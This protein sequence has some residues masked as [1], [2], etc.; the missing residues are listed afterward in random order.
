MREGPIYE[1]L[2]I[3][4]KNYQC[5]IMN[6]CYK[7]FNSDYIRHIRNALSHGTFSINIAG[8]YFKDE[9]YEIVSTPGFLDKIIIW[10]FIL[11]YQC[12]LFIQKENV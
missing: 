5:K 10:I 3:G 9:K 12:V 6:K 8:I 11:Y 2:K 7:L 4:S 1:I